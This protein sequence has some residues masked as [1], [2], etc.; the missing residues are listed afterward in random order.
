VFISV[1]GFPAE[2]KKAPQPCRLRCGGYVPGG[3]MPDYTLFSAN[4]KNALPKKV[5]HTKP[6]KKFIDVECDMVVFP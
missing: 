4:A 3:A 5:K 1:R 6:K 2:I